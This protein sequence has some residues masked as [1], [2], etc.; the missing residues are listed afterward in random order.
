MKNPV[1]TITGIA[2]A[3]ISIIG[4]IGL[5]KQEQAIELTQ[6]VPVIIEA[7]AGLIAIFKTGDK[8]AGV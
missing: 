3:I 8:E 2:L 1:S 4:A 5:V 6:I 7:I